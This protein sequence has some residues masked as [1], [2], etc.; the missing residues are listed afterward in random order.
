MTDRGGPLAA[1]HPI[2]K[3]GHPDG[4]P[5]LADELWFRA[6]GVEIDRIT[7]DGYEA[8]SAITLHTNR[9]R[10][11][12]P[13]TACLLNPQRLQNVL[14][15]A[16]QYG[17]PNLSREQT[18]QIADVALG[19]ASVREIH[20]SEHAAADWGRSY[21][22]AAV[23]HEID[24]DKDPHGRWQTASSVR[25][26][27]LRRAAEGAPSPPWVLVRASDRARLV[28]RPWFHQHVRELA[29]ERLSEQRIASLMAL[30]GWE[31]FPLAR[32]ALTVRDPDAR[33]RSVQLRLYVVHEGWEDP[34]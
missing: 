16:L 10:I 7:T 15:A 23:E 5:W 4:L 30:V 18:R 22:L 26:E 21:V 32:S 8:E 9:G 6:L 12:I 11:V 27:G 13:G 17:A 14:S 1:E 20:A 33:A 19:L 31:S 3:R 24:L 29:G 25:D 28:I 2:P 34:E